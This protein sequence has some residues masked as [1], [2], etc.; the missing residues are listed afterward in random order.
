[1]MEFNDVHLNRC[2]KCDVRAKYTPFPRKGLSGKV[3]VISYPPLNP[4]ASGGKCFF[5]IQTIYPVYTLA[6]GKDNTLPPRSRGGLGW[7]HFICDTFPDTLV[8]VG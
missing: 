3:V 5:T 6:K 1:M 8:S 4:P 7:G 2:F